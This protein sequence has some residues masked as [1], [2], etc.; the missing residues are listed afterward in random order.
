MDELVRKEICRTKKDTI[1]YILIGSVEVEIGKE[2]NQMQHFRI[3][4]WSSF[5]VEKGAYYRIT[6]PG[7]Y[8]T[9]LYYIKS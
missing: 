1:F 2:K 9:V 5:L 7:F 6:N 8:K 3:S 4:E